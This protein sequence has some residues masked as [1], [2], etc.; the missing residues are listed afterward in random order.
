[1]T[2]KMLT[3][4]LLPPQ[5]LGMGQ[6]VK[7]QLFSRTTSTQTNNI[8]TGTTYMHGSRIF[9]VRRGGGGGG[10]GS[11]T[12]FTVYR[13]G[14]MVLLH[15]FQGGVQLFSRGGGG[16]GGVQLPISIETHITITY[17]FPGGGGVGGVW[18]PYP[19]S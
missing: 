16:G 12:Y 11:S 5:T 4:L 10:P 14:P 13:E 2:E 9:F 7:I 3:S 6:Y 18:N 8:C 19:S 15:I 1:M 17:N